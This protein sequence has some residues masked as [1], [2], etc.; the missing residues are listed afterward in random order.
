MNSF[1][2]HI[3]DI[4]TYGNMSVV[5]VEV[6][7]QIQL[8]SIIIDTPETAPYLTKGN[9]VNVLFKEM[10][11]AISTQMELGISIENKISGIISDM[12][13]GELMSRLIV[14]TNFGE[15]VAVISST[16]AN[17]L[18][19]VKKMKVKIMVKMNEIILAP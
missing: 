17:Q 15:V 10:E 2:G 8:I 5:Y 7:N 14:E 18:G 11:V 6:E 19:L 1:H 13:V 4:K 12:E 16:S 9:K 3:R